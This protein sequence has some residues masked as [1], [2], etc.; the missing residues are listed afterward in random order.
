MAARKFGSR[1]MRWLALNAAT[2]LAPSLKRRYPVY[3]KVIPLTEAGDVHFIE[4]RQALPLTFEEAEYAKRFDPPLP[5]TIERSIAL[6]RLEDATVLGSTGAVIDESRGVLLQSRYTADRYGPG[7]SYHDF[8]DMP[9]VRADKPQANYF[10]MVGEYRGHRHFFHFLFDRLPRIFYLLSRFDMGDTAIRG[11]HERRSPRIS[12][13]SLSLLRSA[14]SESAVRGRAGTGT[15][16][17]AH[18]LPD[19]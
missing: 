15:L 2:R 16:A 9:S 10:S 4:E 12:A 3:K 17:S 6:V 14:A 8:V 19:R 11:A 7:A 1:N 13:R 5:E 18:A